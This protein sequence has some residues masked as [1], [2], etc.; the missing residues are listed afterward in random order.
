MVTRTIWQDLY[1]VQHDIGTTLPTHVASDPTYGGT[2][3]GVLGNQ[4]SSGVGKYALPLTDHPNF[5]A[6]SAALDTEQ[7]RGISTRHDSEFNV[8]QTGDPVEFTSPF[9]GHAFNVTGFL[10]SLF[11]TGQSGSGAE[12]SAH[13]GNTALNI[14]RFLPYEVADCVTFSYFTRAVQPASGSDAIDLIVRGGITSSIVFAGESGGVF[15]I[16]ATILGAAWESKDLSS[17]T[18]IL[19]T[20]FDMEQVLKY[21]DCTIAFEDIYTESEN[22]TGLTFDATG[23]TIVRAAGNWTSTPLSLSGGDYIIIKNTDL[24]D[25]RY[26]INT[27]VALTITLD[28]GETLVDEADAEAFVGN[29]TWV[30]VKSPTITFTIPNN[31]VFNYYNDDVAVSAHLGKLTVEGAI[32]IPFSQ[33]TVGTNYMVNRF[34]NGETIRIAWFWG[35]SGG[36]PDIE[37]DHDLG[38][39]DAGADMDRYKNDTTATEPANFFSIV[40]NARCTDYEIT[41]DNELMVECTLQAVKDQIY[42]AVEIYTAYDETKLDWES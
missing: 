6:P 37:E 3:I 19:E 21:Q 32:T 39:G 16:E 26:L 15:N 31:V 35:Q 22:V 36:T 33:S 18:T 29:I 24:N 8:V 23:K 1:G 38:Y 28:S 34:L 2:K 5:K 40:V 25:G 13:T 42:N 27:V 4:A 30:D 7:A 20:S 14:T 12:E 10:L 41:G 11:Q 17:L 9:L